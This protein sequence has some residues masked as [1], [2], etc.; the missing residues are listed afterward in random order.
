M[1]GTYNRVIYWCVL[2]SVYLLSIFCVM[3]TK[4][5]DYLKNGLFSN[6]VSMAVLVIVPIV[7]AVLL[8]LLNIKMYKT[9]FWIC[10]IFQ[11][12]SALCY[13][14]LNWFERL[15]KIELTSKLPSAIAAIAIFL[16]LSATFLSN[17]IIK[18]GIK[19]DSWQANS[20]LSTKILD[21]RKYLASLSMGIMFV[22]T[23][24]TAIIVIFGFVA[25]NPGH[26]A[27]QPALIALVG[28]MIAAISIWL[29]VRKRS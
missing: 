6:I 14:K 7:I 23:M 20:D 21:A 18:H 19:F 3:N 28:I 2:P 9:M 16:V 22:I 5:Y 10:G 8:S 15:F 11:M 1:S 24:V 13:S 12:I 26:T 17:S 4:V 27:I 29:H 25:I